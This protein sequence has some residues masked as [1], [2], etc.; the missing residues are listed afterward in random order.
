MPI[1]V[2]NHDAC[3]RAWF[4]IFIQLPHRQVRIDLEND[5]VSFKKKYVMLIINNHYPFE[6][7]RGVARED[8]IGVEFDDGDSGRIPISQIRVLP[9]DYPISGSKTL[10]F[11][12]IV[13][14]IFYVYFIISSY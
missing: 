14:R 10:I 7:H 11:A 3:T 12:L 9:P 8:E 2:P 1:G 4:L 5:F 6:G 13:D